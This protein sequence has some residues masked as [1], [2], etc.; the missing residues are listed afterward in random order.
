MTTRTRT[1][2]LT[3][4]R[5]LS[6]SL[7]A[8]SGA[9]VLTLGLGACGTTA[10]DEDGVSVEDV[11]EAES[12]VEAEVDEDG[13]TDVD[14]DQ[15]PLGFEGAY[16]SAFTDQQDD[17]IGQDVTVSAAVNTILDDT[18]FTIAGDGSG[19]EPLLVVGATSETAVEVAADQEVYVSGT[20]MEAFVL[21]EVEE[22]LGL[23]LDDELYLE[24]EGETYIDANAVS[25]GVEEGS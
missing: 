18:S 24:W 3:G 17:L 14:V 16:D 8:V 7:V 22:E 20:V 5:R 25:I 4:T 1:R 19:I 12:D 11:N 23:D 15:G 13:S 21:T 10:G 6:R 9:A 2:A